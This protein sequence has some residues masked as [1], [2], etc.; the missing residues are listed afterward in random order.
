MTSVDSEYEDENSAGSSSLTKQE[1]ENHFNE[2]LSQCPTRDS[3]KLFEIYSKFQQDNKTSCSASL[4][5]LRKNFGTLDHN[6]KVMKSRSLYSGSN[7]FKLCEETK[8][9]SDSEWKTII[10]AA[11][12]SSKKASC[13]TV[14][15]ISERVKY[16]KE[17][18]S[19]ALMAVGVVNEN[20]V[21]LMSQV[22][23]QLPRNARRDILDE[24]APAYRERLWEDIRL[25][26]ND[27]AP[28]IVNTHKDR[29]PVLRNI[30]PR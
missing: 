13:N 3:A 12:F 28:N 6:L 23:G 11:L 4:N 30:D 27:L 17:S 8:C 1:F 24:G 9:I 10:N 14:S 19:I 2:A 16:S 7:L 5:R 18:D 22:H 29:H 26:I 25:A 15:P 21:N 20:V